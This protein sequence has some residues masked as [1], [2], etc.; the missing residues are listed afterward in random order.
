MNSYIAIPNT[1]DTM[2]STTSLHDYR[3]MYPNTAEVPTLSQGSLL[4]GVLFR[5]EQKKRIKARRVER[6]RA[7]QRKVRTF[8]MNFIALLT[9][10][11]STVTHGSHQMQTATA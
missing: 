3:N 8:V 9:P 1:T 11:R 6:R 10:V 7:I 5:I 4:A 2:Y